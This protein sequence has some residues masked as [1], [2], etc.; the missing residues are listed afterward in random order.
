MADSKETLDLTKLDGTNFPL[1][2]FEITLTIESKELTGYLDGTAQEPNKTDKPVEW[3]TW[4]KKSSQ[5][6]VLL[7]SSVA[8]NLRQHLINCTTPSQI[9]KKLHD[10][11]AECSEDAVMSAWSQFYAFKIKDGESIAL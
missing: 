10:L 11:Y 6:S 4:K 3:Q 7:L 2:K 1:W 8:K 9:W 5:T